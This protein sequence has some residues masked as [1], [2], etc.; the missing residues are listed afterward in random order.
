MTTTVAVRPL[1][2]TACGVV[3]PAGLGLGALEE[4]LR[5]GVDDYTAPDN[6]F[7]GAVDGYPPRPLWAVPDLRVAEHLGRKGLRHIDRFTMLGLIACKL[8][9]DESG[10]ALTDED[11]ADTGVVMA[12]NTGSLVSMLEVGRDT[13]L[14]EKPYLVNP[15]RFPNVVTNA[16]TGQIAIRNSLTGVNVVVSGGQAAG[17]AAVRFAR[18]AIGDERSRRLLVGG[19]EELSQVAAWGWHKS[20]AL[21]ED[22]PVG[23]GSA[24][25]LVE[26]A[27]AASTA[28][29]SGLADLLACEVGYYGAGDSEWRARGLRSCVE[30]A[31]ERSGVGADDVDVVSLGATNHRRLEL[32]EDRVVQEVL[33]RPV[34]RVRVS[35]VLGELYSASVPLQIAAVLALWREPADHAR[36]AL[37]TSVGGDG[38]A[39][40]LVVRECR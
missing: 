4:A 22:A 21:H 33:D 9:L 38:N 35:E 11:R 27:E 32:L 39:G 12:T 37:V 14:Q 16:C 24:V 10:T 40:C 34:P 28:G 5:S 30:R 1:T 26:D 2:I 25:F 17:L 19:V 31:L 13:L 8:A 29:R 36:T 3:S 7:E 18:T 6:P 20:G 15:A 23:E